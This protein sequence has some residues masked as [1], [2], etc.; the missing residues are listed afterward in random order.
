MGRGDDVGQGRAWIPL[1]KGEPSRGE[2]LRF[3]AASRSWV[4]AWALVGAV[5]HRLRRPLLR[6]PWIEM[7]PPSAIA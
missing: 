5:K 4:P 2:S 7:W 1:V 6:L 3:G